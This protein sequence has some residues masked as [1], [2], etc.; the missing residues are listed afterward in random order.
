M[1]WDGRPV[2]TVQ[3]SVLPRW[4]CE[5]REAVRVIEPHSW[6]FGQAVIPVKDA[7]I[8]ST[9]SPVVNVTVTF[10]CAPP[11]LTSSTTAVYW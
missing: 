1:F 3:T 5:A 10:R 6:P 2:A 8:L 7:S 11:V 9:D 4:N